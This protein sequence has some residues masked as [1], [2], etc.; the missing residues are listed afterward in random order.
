MRQ[1]YEPN[2]NIK[3]GSYYISELLKRYQGNLYHA[4]A[5]YNAGE[6]RVDRWRKLLKTDDNDFFMENIEFEQ[7]RK[8]VRGA[9][10]FYWTYYLM[11]YPNRTP[12]DLLGYP[13]R[14]SLRANPFDLKIRN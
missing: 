9:M 1:L 14:I 10:K 12:Q 8:Y 3:L 13:E 5:A 2:F 11:I 4:L 6:H 7:T